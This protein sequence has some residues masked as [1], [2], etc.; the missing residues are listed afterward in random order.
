[1]P[2]TAG[3]IPP[4]APGYEEDQ[5]MQQHSSQYWAEH[6]RKQIAD[7]PDIQQYLEE[8]A[9]QAAQTTDNS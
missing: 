5:Q 1:E 8:E 7:R 9:R 6:F 2:F 4:G 3:M